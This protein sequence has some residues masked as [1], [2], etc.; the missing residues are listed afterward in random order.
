[1]T[2]ACGQAGRSI[3]AVVSRL[4]LVFVDEGHYEPAFRWSQDI[5]ALDRPTVLLTATPYRNDEKFFAIGNAR[6]RFPHHEA[7]EER[8]LRE[9]RF[10]EVTRATPEAFATALIALVHERFGGDEV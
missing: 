7:V 1:M 2:K 8:F 3:V 10:G 6:L 9:P 4:V 5:R